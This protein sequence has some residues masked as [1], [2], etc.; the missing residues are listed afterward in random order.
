MVP[1]AETALKM[2]QTR[3]SASRAITGVGGSKVSTGAPVLNCMD[4]SHIQEMV[5]VCLIE[6][7]ARWRMIDAT[8]TKT[9]CVRFSC[10]TGWTGILTG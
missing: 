1:A 2:F 9:L 6:E 3:A 8:N 10:V 7:N 4:C 5:T